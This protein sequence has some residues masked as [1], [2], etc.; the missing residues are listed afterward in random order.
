MTGS[1]RQAASLN[2]CI[3]EARLKPTSWAGPGAPAS[4]SRSLLDTWNSQLR[5]AVA[6]GVPLICSA[7]TTTMHARNQSVNARTKTRIETLRPP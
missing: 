5:A 7:T 2:T 4:R 1:R 3:S 6:A